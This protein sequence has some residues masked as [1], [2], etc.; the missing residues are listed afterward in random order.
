[1]FN[2]L[3]NSP[4]YTATVVGLI[5]GAFL[6]LFLIAKIVTE[7]KIWTDNSATY[8]SRTI[9][10]NGVGEEKAIPNIATFNFSVTE[11]SKTSEEAQN[12]ATTKINKAIDFLK[13]NGV[14]E[15]DIKTEGYSVYPKYDL[16]RPCTA[17]DCPPASNTVVGYEVS[18]NVTVMVRDQDQAGRFLTELGKIG[19]SNVG[20]LDFVIE[21]DEI[22]KEKAKDKAITDAKTKAEILAKQLGVKLGDILSFGEEQPYGAYDNYGMGGAETMSAKATVAPQLP[23][24]EN[25]YT[26]KVWINYELK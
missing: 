3:L 12:K 22:L 11:E 15:K 20:G 5:V 9:T 16:V 14:E 17:F 18:Q 2:R 6:S 21:D 10:V 8:P 4:S 26:S 23:A 7:V 24:G 25:V 13:T 1:M 19:V